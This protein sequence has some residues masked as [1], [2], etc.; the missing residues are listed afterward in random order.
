MKSIY[1]GID[2]SKRTLDVC[3]KGPDGAQHLKIDN[4]VKSIKKLCR[5]LNKVDDQAFIAMENTGHYNHQLYSV[6]TKY[7][8]NVYVVDP[9]HI[10][11][12]IGLVRGKNDK[13]DARRIATF[14]ER[15]KQDFQP[16]EPL[17][18]SIY[19]L[20]ILLAER[21]AEVARIRSLK[22]RIDGLKQ[23]KS[24]SSAQTLISRNKK[25]IQRTQQRVK[26]IEKLI[27]EEI[28]KDNTLKT[29]VTRIKTVPG[30]GDVTAWLIAVKTH[31]F[32]RLLDPRKLACFAGVV[33]FEQQSGSSLKTQPRVSKMADRTLKTVLQMAAM[34]AVRMT[35]DLQ[36]Y[37][38]R[39]IE[40]GKN[41][42]SV[43]NA[44]RN[45]LIHIAMALVK[46]KTY[47]QNR[48]V[49]S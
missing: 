6:L 18:D 44:V 36:A 41:K 37:Y 21:R 13:V 39:K 19:S 10:K 24:V 2:V 38:E 43:L 35:N 12:S 45:K 3:L 22:Q 5:Q 11:R 34:R 40:E 42:M 16:W 30:I 28:A 14:I 8:F 49:L 1:V 7:S 4:E 25:E 46:N 15:N 47:Y 48:L 31:G 20:K 27:R 26:E 23:Q 9:K 29:E 17:S 33:P 32:K